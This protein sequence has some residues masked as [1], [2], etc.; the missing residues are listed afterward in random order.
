[1]PTKDPMGE[2]SKESFMT[3]TPPPP[4]PAMDGEPAG[5]VA[6][7]QDKEK[8]KMEVKN[9]VIFIMVKF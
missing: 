6:P 9:R 3:P 7:K 1:V 8:R 4:P 5:G 2:S